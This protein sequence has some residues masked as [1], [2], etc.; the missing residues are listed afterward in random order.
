MAALM[1]PNLRFKTCLSNFEW[2]DMLTYIM[3]F[4]NG[5]HKLKAVLGF[6][7]YNIQMIKLLI[8]RSPF[9][10]LTECLILTPP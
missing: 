2:F 8:C 6:R 3:Y 9:F 7:I 10:I 4:V 5:V 1:R